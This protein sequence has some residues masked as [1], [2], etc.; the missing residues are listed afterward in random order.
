MFALIKSAAR[1]AKKHLSGQF[2][3]KEIE[4]NLAAMTQEQ[5]IA[6]TLRN[7]DRCNGSGMTVSR[8]E[9]F[10]ML[11]IQTPNETRKQLA[12]ATGV[13]EDS[14]VTVMRNH[15]TAGGTIYACLGLVDI[16]LGD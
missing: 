10:R 2:G 13:S 9:A 12:T 16:Y 7:V 11:E 14:L 4:L 1:A 15:L 3:R 6:D 8:E 5:R